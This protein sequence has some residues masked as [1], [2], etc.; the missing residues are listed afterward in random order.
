MSYDPDEECEVGM[1]G[2]CLAAAEYILDE[3]KPVVRHVIGEMMKKEIEISTSVER[4]GSVSITL[5]WD[6]SRI[7][8]RPLA[9]I[10]AEREKEDR[11]LQEEADEEERE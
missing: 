4:D 7:A 2:F 3:I 1:A 8:R 5:W 6:G 9:E 10:M 11:E